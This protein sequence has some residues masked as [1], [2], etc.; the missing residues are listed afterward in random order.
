LKLIYIS[1][2]YSF[3]SQADNV[4]VQLEAGH[5]ILDMGHVPSVPLLNHYLQ[6]HRPRKPEDWLAMD[7]AI[8]PRCDVLLRLPG[9]SEGADKEVAHA[10]RNAVPVCVGWDDLEQ[11]LGV[12]KGWGLG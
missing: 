6:I 3:G 10:I 11:F 1:S 12:D 8:I 4:R 7:F 5:R 2:P 9:E